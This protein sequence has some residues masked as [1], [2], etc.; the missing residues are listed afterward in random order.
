MNTIPRNRRNGGIRVQPEVWLWKF[1]NPPLGAECRNDCITLHCVPGRSVCLPSTRVW[2]SRAAHYR[3]GVREIDS[4]VPNGA[5]AQRAKCDKHHWAQGTQIW[6]SHKRG[7]SPQV[8]VPLQKS[9]R[10][11]LQEQVLDT[12][13]LK[14]GDALLGHLG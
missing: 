7:I 3:T 10:P 8:P 5:P 9:A 12:N 13:H 11:R 2:T 6:L 4:V 1:R 14:D